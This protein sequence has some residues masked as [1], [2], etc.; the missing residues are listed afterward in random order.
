[1]QRFMFVNSECDI[2]V[3]LLC[4]G[5]LSLIASD[6]EDESIRKILPIEN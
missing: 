3:Y 6:Q 4:W 1:M 5:S 2:S